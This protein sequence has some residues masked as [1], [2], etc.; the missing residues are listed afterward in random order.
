MTRRFTRN[1]LI[2]ALA[3]IVA[4]GGAWYGYSEYVKA[5]FLR[6]LSL[7]FFSTSMIGGASTE[8]E[9]AAHERAKEL[10]INLFAAYRSH[11]EANARFDLAWMLITNES[12][13]YYEFARVNIDSIPWPEVRIWVSRRNQGSLSPEYRKKLLQLVLASPTSEGKLAA[14][15]WYRQQNRIEESEDAYYSAMTT[16]LFWDAL[17]SAD[18]LLDSVRYRG[19]AIHHLLSVVRDSKRFHSRAALS[20]LNAFGVADE[21]KS[22]VDACEREGPDGPNRRMLVERITQLADRKISESGSSERVP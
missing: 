4:I 6:E 8:K 14:A 22:L 17:D 12:V 7:V 20:L 2:G 21:L 9:Q 18:K 3:A 11:S 16:G 1:C 13:E 5:Q 10:G 19:D 15:R